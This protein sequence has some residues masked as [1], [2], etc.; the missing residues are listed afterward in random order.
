MKILILGATGSLGS[1]VIEELLKEEGAQLRLYA[2]NPAKVEKFKNERAQIVRGDVLDEGALKDALDGVDAVYAGLAG[3]LEAMAQTLVAA[4]DAKGVK[5]LVW[6][7][8]YGIYG[9]AGRGSMPPSGY[10]ISAAVVEGSGLDYMIIRPQ[11][12]SGADEIDYETTSW[13]K[14][15]R[16]KNPD[17]KISRRLIANLVARCVFENFGIRDS[18]GIN[19]PAR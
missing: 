18:I 2:R 1:Y 17:A 7:S 4:M 3:E 6:I 13:N 11:W 15:E 16:F 19:K 12:F 8:S 10:V 14:K 5:R 9:E